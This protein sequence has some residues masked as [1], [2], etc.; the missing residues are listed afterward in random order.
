MLVF[1][2]PEQIRFHH[3]PEWAAVRAEWLAYGDDGR[4]RAAMLRGAEFCARR[5]EVTGWIIDLRRTEGA[6][7]RFDSVW[8]A[9]VLQPA[10]ARTGLRRFINLLPPRLTDFRLATRWELGPGGILTADAA[11]LE[12]VAALL[13]PALV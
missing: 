4:R 13:A 9:R 5:P 10:W 11:D 6:L 2:I 3:H 8:Q 1:S 7:L 12:Q